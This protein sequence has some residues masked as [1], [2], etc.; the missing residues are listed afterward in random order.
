[1]RA[2]RRSSN[3]DHFSHL[4]TAGQALHDVGGGIGLLVQGSNQ[5]EIGKVTRYGP[6][7]AIWPPEKQLCS[8]L[9]APKA[10]RGSPFSFCGD[11]APGIKKKNKTTTHMWGQG[12]CGSKPVHTVCKPNKKTWLFV[13]I[14]SYSVP[15]HNKCIP[16]IKAQSHFSFYTCSVARA[17]ESQEVAERLKS[18]YCF[19]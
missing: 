4:R 17:T 6:L 13:D 19:T 18:K 15:Y 11:F 12:K 2:S 3:L 7:K 16:K 9:L 1:M 5:Y 14:C 8:V 10:S